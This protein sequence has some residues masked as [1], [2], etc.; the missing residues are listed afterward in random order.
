[1]IW[2]LLCYSKKVELDTVPLA[3]DYQS[4]NTPTCMVYI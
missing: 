3:P 2:S 4:E 1:M